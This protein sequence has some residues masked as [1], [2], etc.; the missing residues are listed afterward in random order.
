MACESVV[1]KNIIFKVLI[2][3][4]IGIAGYLAYNVITDRNRESVDTVLE[5]KAEKQQR[6]IVELEEKVATLQEKLDDTENTAIPK[7]KI[8]QTF[9]EQKTE[10]SLLVVQE[11][12]CEELNRRI[13]S[14]LKYLDEKKYIQAH[15]LNES[16]HEFFQK[17]VSRLTE[18]E[19]QISGEMQELPVLMKNI[20]HFYRVLGRK[21]LEI[22]RDVIHNEADIIE[23]VMT[24]FNQYY[25]PDKECKKMTVN[26]PSLETS[27]NY[28]LFFLNTLAGK[29]YLLRRDSKMRIITSYYCL[30]II[31]RA[32]EKGLNQYGFD[33]RPQIVMLLSDI[34]DHKRLVYKAYYL[35]E[36]KRLQ[37]KYSHQ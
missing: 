15:G 29:N 32:N 13:T 9:G 18:N 2:G 27:Y 37:V 20:A 26:L 7:E 28:A 12:S 35:E 10:V 24:T 19:P 36:L 3:T 11:L 22:I 14:F 17:T 25:Q 4:I 34:S 6:T 30:L 23:S 31:D 21:R 5:Q 16:T 8:A 1:M 33:I